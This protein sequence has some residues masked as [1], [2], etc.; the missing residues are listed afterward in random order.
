MDGWMDEWMDEWMEGCMNIWIYGCMD[1]WTSLELRQVTDARSCSPIQC[2][3]LI[4]FCRT[5][6]P[7]L[8]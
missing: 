7:A 1:A 3:A 5:C 6:I 8:L 2:I 4:L